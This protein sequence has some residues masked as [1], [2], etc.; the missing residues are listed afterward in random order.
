M[1]NAGMNVNCVVC[2]AG[3]KHAIA[4]DEAGRP[5]PIHVAYICHCGKE[6]VYG[7]DEVWYCT[8]CWKEL[9]DRGDRR[10]TET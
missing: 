9:H 8:E 1:Y 2:T 7:R 10:Q 5:W 4:Y 3:Q 6:A